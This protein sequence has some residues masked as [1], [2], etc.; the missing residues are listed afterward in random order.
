MRQPISS[1]SFYDITSK[2]YQN[3]SFE[4]AKYLSA[5][6]LIV[7]QKMS[8]IEELK[9]LEVGAG[10]GIRTRTIISGLTYKKLLLIE[11]S[12]VFASELLKTFDK[13]EVHQG[14]VEDY[15][16]SDVY[17]NMAFSLWNVIGHVPEPLTYLKS[18][19]KL[20]EN[21]GIFIFDFNNRLN[22]KEYG[23]YN[24]ARNWLR[25][26]LSGDAGQFTL[27]KDG[28]STPVYIYQ[29]A[30]IKSLCQK[31]GFVV[32]QKVY[33]NYET[34]NIEG[35]QLSGQILLICRKVT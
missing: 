9:L 16:H 32:E 34:G 27:N 23:F 20:L 33:V 25:G 4:R 1:K 35:N 8:K 10:N 24:V 30:E 18:I 13:T 2:S 11:E 12:E 28:V 14:S 7:T 6:D 21:N 31:S 17:F 22:I 5:I 26:L 15:E 29:L 19:N 3:T